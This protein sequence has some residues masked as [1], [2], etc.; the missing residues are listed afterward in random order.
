MRAAGLL[1]EAG[2]RGPRVRGARGRRA[3]ETAAFADLEVHRR[4]LAD[5]RRAERFGAALAL[6]APGRT[7]LEIGAGTGVL[8]VLAARAG[9]RRVI[10]VEETPV[11]ALAREVVGRNGAAAVVEVREG[12]SR[13]LALAPGEARPDLLVAELLGGD[14]LDERLLES[15]ADARERLLAPRAA[16][17]P[18]RLAIFAAPLEARDGHLDAVR[19]AA[20]LDEAGRAL[21][22]DLGPVREA[23]AAGPPA[24]VTA[25]VRDLEPGG[26][27]RL[28]SEGLHLATFDLARGDPAVLRRAAAS[29]DV[30]A[31]GRA[32]P[33]GG[34]R[35]NAVA[36]WFRAELAPG[37]EIANAPFAPPT[38]WGQLIVPLA[39]PALLAAG[40]G[41]RLEIGFRRGSLARCAIV[42]A[43]VE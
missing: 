3:L 22:I 7:V 11:A 18:R 25:E 37:I 27:A 4:L 35:A 40:R 36:I 38:H 43:R 30:R 16:T 6:L 20:E 13:E 29:L 24:A 31:A 21:G 12:S 17:I 2:G 26:G 42:R 14:P 32:L 34:G 1:V 9:A 28:L 39:A 10:A 41:F 5:V 15:V 19:R 23:I 8:A 33:G